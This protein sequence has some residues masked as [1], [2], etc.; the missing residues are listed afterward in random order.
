MTPRFLSYTPFGLRLLFTICVMVICLFFIMMLSI[1]FA[2]PIFNKSITVILFSLS[3]ISQEN[4]S[5]LKYFQAAQTIGLFIIPAIIIAWLEGGPVL[6]QLQFKQIRR[7]LPL[8]LA[9]LIMAAVIPFINWLANVNQALKLPGF[10]SGIEQWMI[11]TEDTAGKI[12]KLFLTS[13]SVSI[14]LINLI[15]IAALPAL[16]EEM[17]FRGIIQRY[18][19]NIT[20]GINFWR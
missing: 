5:L 9:L 20:Y 13:G 11:G 10:L 3:I 14:W 4:I 15:I 16:G 17:L 18:F 6:I 7:F 1:L 8:L 2:I 12:T 19:I